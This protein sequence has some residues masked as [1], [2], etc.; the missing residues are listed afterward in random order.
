MPNSDFVDNSPS[1]A[2]DGTAQT[3]SALSGAAYG[4]AV[5]SVVP[6]IGT[7]IGAVIGGVVGYFSAPKKAVYKPIN[8]DAIVK[9]ARQN[10]ADNYKNSLSLEANANPDSA[11]ARG[12]TDRA[13]GDVADHTSKG[14][15][16]RDAM[17]DDVLNGKSAALYNESSDSIL[18]QLRLGGQLDPE[19]QAAIT[20]GA[21]SRGGQ[22]GLTG[23]NAGRGLVARD[24]GL[25]SMGLLQSRQ[26]A[27]EQAAQAGVSRFAVGNAAAGLDAS[28]AAS[29]GSIF[30]ARGLPTAGLDPE[31]AAKLRVANTVGQNKV[32]LATLSMDN[33]AR[34]KNVQSVMSLG[35]SFAGGMGGGAGG[36]DTST[37]GS[38]NDMVAAMNRTCWVAREVYGADNPEWEEFRAKMLAEMPKEFVDFY[39]ENGPEIAEQIKDMPKLKKFLRGLMDQIKK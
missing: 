39:I 15:R 35:S 26:G 25:T 20:R 24:L 8:V 9:E 5:G 32:D 31:F 11:Y 23:S 7:V 4:A 13:L 10:Y 33:A 3:S 29:L 14:F 6:V 36:M 28:T 21:L 18:Q 22:S 17:L 30:N 34:S 38:Y 16:A 27:A 19:T 12:A 2:T 37:N 1:E